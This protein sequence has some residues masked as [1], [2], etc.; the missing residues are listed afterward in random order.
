MTTKEILRVNLFPN[1][2][3]VASGRQ[4]DV[5]IDLQ[6][7]GWNTAGAHSIRLINSNDTGAFVC[8]YI[9]V[10]A[11]S[12]YVFRCVIIYASETS[13]RG[14]IAEFRDKDENGAS[15]ANIGNTK[16]DQS[17]QIL[18]FTA[19]SNRVAL[20]FRGAKDMAGKTGVEVWNPQLEL[21]STFDAAVS[22]GGLRFF[23]WNTMPR[24]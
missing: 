2:R 11:G 1:A 8:W 20:I 7:I 24:P 10:T 13:A 4:P 17:E 5:K 22:G 19:A 3:C 9:P 6:S 21:A 12:A 15:L 23:A 14:Y 16:P 18:R